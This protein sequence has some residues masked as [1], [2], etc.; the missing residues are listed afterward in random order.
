MSDMTEKARSFTEHLY[1]PYAP[2]LVEERDETI[3]K[4][5]DYNHIYPLDRTAREAKLREI[6]G[7]VGKTPV[8][9]QP[10]FT[11]YGSNTTVGDNFYMNVNGKLMDSG[12]ITIGDNVFIA[13]NVCIITEQHPLNVEQRNEGL[14]YTHPI[15]IGNNVWIATNVNVLPGVTIGDNCVIGAGSVVTRDIPANSLAVGV[16]AKVIRHL[17]NAREN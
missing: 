1:Q 2:E 5:Y 8:I 13:P 7:G 3:K 17:D 9:E 6:L 14:E 16:P 11:T 12:K 4:V 15:T 10:F